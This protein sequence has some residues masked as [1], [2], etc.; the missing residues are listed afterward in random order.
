MEPCLTLDSNYTCTQPP[1]KFNI[2]RP[3][4]CQTAPPTTEEPVSSTLT[5]TVI[6]TASDII[7]TV[8]TNASST[9]TQSSITP[10]STTSPSTSTLTTESIESTTSVVTPSNC[11][12]DPCT[13]H[14]RND[15][16][17]IALCCSI[18]AIAIIV[19]VII[20]IWYK[21]RNRR[22]NE[23][24][25]E[26]GGPQPLETQNST[27]GLIGNDEPDTGGNTYSVEKEAFSSK[28][29]TNNGIENK[30]LTEDDPKKEEKPAPVVQMTEL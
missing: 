22:D 3:N 12:T 30:G 15:P 7:S 6:S 8:I 13:T 21:T 27:Y 14:E 2:T 28:D 26:N 4:F 10:G 17:L 11:T 16:L 18:P 9:L 20:I 29:E 24:Q 5:S 23:K 25:N 1:P 19:V